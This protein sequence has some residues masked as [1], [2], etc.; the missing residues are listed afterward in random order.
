MISALH[1]TIGGSMKLESVLSGYCYNDQ[2]AILLLVLIYS[3]TLVRLEEDPK[4]VFLQ[5]R[6]QEF[7][8]GLT[9]S[10]LQVPTCVIESINSNPLDWFCQ[11]MEYLDKNNI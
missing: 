7:L 8:E 10:S 1:L 3:H 6:K 5:T 9:I 2:K 4:L 11:T